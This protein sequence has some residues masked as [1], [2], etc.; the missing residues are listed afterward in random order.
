MS[1]AYSC[2]ITKEKIIISE[3]VPHF[4]I[5]DVI[6]VPIDV[7]NYAIEE[8]IEVFGINKKPFPLKINDL[9]NG[10]DDVSLTEDNVSRILEIIDLLNLRG[11]SFILFHESDWADIPDAHTEAA[12]SGGELVEDG[13]Y[14]E[15]D[16]GNENCKYGNAFTKSGILA[17]KVY[18]DRSYDD[19]ITA[20]IENIFKPGIWRVL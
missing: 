12:F 15:S 2:I 8:F 10:Y 19:A 16:D 1:S 6:T 11:K 4:K 18:Y 13:Y 3:N 5:D 7:S 20:Y 14:M 17:S 9:Y